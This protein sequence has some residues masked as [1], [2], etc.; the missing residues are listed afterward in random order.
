[1]PPLFSVVIPTLGSEARLTPLIAGLARQTLPRERFEVIVVFDGAQPTTAI[2]GALEAIGARIVHL[3][4][5]GGPSL[6]RNRGA[7]SAT[8]EFLAWTEDDVVPE[9]DWL[10][11][12]AERIAAEPDLDVIEGLTVKPGG[13]PVRIRADESAQYIPCN[14]FVRRNLFEKIGGYH[15]GYYDSENGVYFREDADLG[16]TL[17]KA[18]ARVGREPKAIVTHPIEHQGFLDPL[19]WAQRYEM[20]ALLAA[21]HPDRFRERIEVHRLG[22]FRIRRP[23][24]RACFFHVIALVAAAAALLAGQPG[25]A[26]LFALLAL[27]ALVVVWSKWRFAPIKLPVVVL[28]PWVMVRAWLWGWVRAR[29]LMAR[30]SSEAAAR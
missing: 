10:A 1:V 24:V 13:R 4:A 9:P 16:Y 30:P 8:G 11:R 28:V 12:A 6:A 20:D 25:A 22:P 15:E 26:A 19:R 7:A 17:E 29:R 5:R 18:G 14:L 27:A 21:R 2:R 3:A 23:V